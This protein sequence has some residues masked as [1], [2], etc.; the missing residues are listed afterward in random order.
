MKLSDTFLEYIEN[1]VRPYRSIKTVW[2]FQFALKSITQFKDPP[3]LEVSQEFVLSWQKKQLDKGL[4]PNTI[5][6]Y[7]EKLRKVLKYARAKGIKCMSPDLVHSPPKRHSNPEWFSEA[8]VSKIIKLAL[9]PRERCSKLNRTRLGA[10]IALLYSTGLRVSEIAKLDVENIKSE[11]IP[12]IGKQNKHRVVFVDNRSKRLINNYLKLRTDE[13]PALFVSN[14][15]ARLDT[16]KIREQF[17]C[18]SKLYGKRIHPHA[19]RHSYATNLLQNGCH[20]YTLQ[21]LMGHSNIVS[22]SV[23]LHVLDPELKEAYSKFHSC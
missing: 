17:R 19:L 9:K 16:C 7:T 20:I 8:E 23:Y 14:T 18:L 6:G 1:Y 15:G 12:I 5:R 4:S 22:T 10:L 13:N 11:T 21:R 3:I 2:Q